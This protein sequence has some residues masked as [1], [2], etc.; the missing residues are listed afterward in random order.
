[1]GASPQSWR[2]DAAFLHP[3]VF[4]LGKLHKPRVTDIRTRGWESNEEANE[5]S[6]IR[7]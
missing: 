7:G 6:E 1:M 5:S 3:D 4:C 2:K